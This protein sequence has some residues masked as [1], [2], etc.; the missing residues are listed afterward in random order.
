MNQMVFVGILFLLPPVAYVIYILK[1]SY[2]EL[3]EEMESFLIEVIIPVLMAVSLV[4]GLALISKG[5]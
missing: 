3:I 5:K 1:T 2:Y 4:I